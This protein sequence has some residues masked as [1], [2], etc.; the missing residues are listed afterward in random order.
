MDRDTISTLIRDLIART[1]L[2]LAHLPE[3]TPEQLNAHPGGHPNSPAWLLWH[4]GREIDVQLAHLSGEEEVWPQIRESLGLGELGDTLGYGHSADQARAIRS[5][6]F[7][8]LVN[9]IDR[10]LAA[11]T[12]HAAQVENW[13]EVID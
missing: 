9:Y 5:D 6:D 12:R 3:M 10:V 2:S 8:G 11:A 1:A 7:R 4:T 13:G